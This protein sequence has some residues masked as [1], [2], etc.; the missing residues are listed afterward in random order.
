MYIALNSFF[1]VR[2]R[3]NNSRKSV[4]IFE[5]LAAMRAANDLALTSHL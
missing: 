4:D 1:S 2:S 3:N 5:Y